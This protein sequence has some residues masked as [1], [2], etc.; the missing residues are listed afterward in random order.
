MKA[1]QLHDKFT[2][3]IIGTVLL[4]P[5]VEFSQISDAWDNYQNDY[6]S[7]REEEADIYEFVKINANLCEVLNID[8]YQPGN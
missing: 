5:F 1:I 8:F 4:K 3:E 7:N 6:N 2:E